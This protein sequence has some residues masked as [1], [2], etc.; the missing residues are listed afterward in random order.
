MINDIVGADFAKYENNETM[1]LGNNQIL[2]DAINFQY[3]PYPPTDDKIHLR[4]H[5]L[6]F[7]NDRKYYAPSIQLAQ[8]MAKLTDVY[9]YRFDLKPRTMTEIPDDVG[10]PHGFEQI[11]VW[12]LP[13]WVAQSGEAQQWDNSDKRVSDIIMTLWANFAKYTNPTQVG[14]YIKWEKFTQENPGIL[15]IDK[16]FNMSDFKSLNFRA[17]QFWNDYYPSVLSFAAQC[18]NMS[19]S[20]AYLSVPMTSTSAFTLCLLLQLGIVLHFSISLISH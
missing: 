17:V 9:A 2:T 15:I 6:N 10:V 14:V 4:N 19:D 20:S 7:L 18:C 16:S 8:H 12:G 5:Y 3:R 11:F 13:Y 1:C